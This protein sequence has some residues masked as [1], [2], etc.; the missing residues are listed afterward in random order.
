VIVEVSDPVTATTSTTDAICHD[1]CDGT[2]TLTVLTG[3]PAYTMQWSGNVAGSQSME[4]SNLCA[5][6]YGITITDANGC[7]GTANYTI[8]EPPPLVIDA[9][10][11]GDENCIGSCDGFLNISDAEGVL[12]SIDGGDTWVSENV[13]GD[14]C[15]GGY[16]VMMQDAN[17]CLASSAVHIASPPP[18]AAGFYAAP[19]TMS[20]SNTTVAFTNQSGYAT[21]FLWDFGGLATSTEG[22]P[23]FTFP[24]VL[25]DVYTVCL[26][27]MDSHGCADSICQ[28]IVV[29]DELYVTVPNAFSPN[30]DD[31]NDL[32]VPVF[33]IPANAE[34]YK[35][36]IFDRWGLLI[37]T[38]ETVGE[39]W[40]GD[41][42]GEI[43]QQD[44]YEWKLHCKDRITRE[45]YD[46]IGHV[47]VV[48]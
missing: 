24:D 42:N 32:F 20:V 39:T 30:G 44:V 27:A 2:A 48:K 15:A 43:V 5:G 29:L 34:E 4:A 35:F 8:G 9:I 14:L 1:A 38:S 11:M 46:P 21:T 12:F 47:T 28:P 23:T 7:I 16:L 22:N 41:Y 13:I 33:N 40:N 3:T 17:G 31:I 45:E 10:S 18:V 25:G 19:D 37:F 6:S 36:M 26:T